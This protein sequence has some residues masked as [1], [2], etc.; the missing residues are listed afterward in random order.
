MRKNTCV[1]LLVG[2]LW[3]AVLPLYATQIDPLRWEQMAVCCDFAGIVECTTAGGGVAE[4]KI[5]DAWKGTQDTKPIR[6]RVAANYWEPQFP[7]ALIGERYLVFA[8]KSNTHSNI[9]STTLGGPVPLWWRNI[10]HEYKL[11]L[12]QGRYLIDKEQKVFTN[13]FNE[14]NRSYQKT[15]VS[16]IKE[17]VKGLVSKTKKL[18][19]L[20]LLKILFKKY[21]M[22]R[23]SQRY[24]SDLDSLKRYKS[25]NKKELEESIKKLDASIKKYEQEAPMVAKLEQE[26]QSEN[27]PIQIIDKV[28]DF[29]ISH[30]EYKNNFKAWL[31]QGI[32]TIESLE[33]LKKRL[34]TIKS[35][36]YEYI[37]RHLPSQIEKRI[38]KPIGQSNNSKPPVITGT[39]LPEELDE[40]QKM[41]KDPEKLGDYKWSKSFNVLV[42][43]R[44][45]YV[46]KWLKDLENPKRKWSDEN[47]G[48]KIS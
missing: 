28:F 38:T 22:D 17:Q 33:H 23:H 18:Q 2:V 26:V 4:Y 44:P 14:S 16:N 6:I 37:Q 8:Y 12:F 11:P 7:L 25:K 36:D 34:A 32:R 5:I 42:E 29:S 47:M 39:Y 41:L 24:Q 48:S 19:E 13:L 43:N 20:T 30:K 46:A 9:A 45:V 31:Q 35:E 21:F 3:V 15:P 1:F 10:P 27:D 40:H